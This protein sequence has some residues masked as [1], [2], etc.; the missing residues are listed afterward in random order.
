MFQ[1]IPLDDKGDKPFWT[2]G[3]FSIYQIDNPDFVEYVLSGSHIDPFPVLRLRGSM[4]IALIPQMN[5]L[6]D[7][8]T[9]KG[10]LSLA[11]HTSDLSRRIISGIPLKDQ[12]DRILKHEAGR[13]DQRDHGRRKRQ[14]LISNLRNSDEDEWSQAASKIKSISSFD[15]IASVNLMYEANKDWQAMSRTLRDSSG[16]AQAFYTLDNFTWFEK[17]FD[18]PIGTRVN[19]IKFL[20]VAPWHFGDDRVPGWGT[21]AMYEIAKRTVQSGRSWLV[22]ESLGEQSDRFYEAVGMKRFGE[23]RYKTQDDE[24]IVTGRYSIDTA[25]LLRYMQA[26]EER[27]RNG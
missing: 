11:P 25:G 13:H 4:W 15:A 9:R 1:P 27:K 18:I 16:R 10:Y 3:R 8:L 14:Y 24:E 5:S 21:A 26:Y 12:I 22:L 7:E 2:D 23:F 17:G 6:A 20:G 19:E